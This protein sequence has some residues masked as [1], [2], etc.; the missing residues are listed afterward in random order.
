[1]LMCD[2]DQTNTVIINQ[3][4]I[5]KKFFLK[6]RE[7]GRKKRKWK[8]KKKKTKTKKKTKKPQS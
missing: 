3:L 5:K 6:E 1:M 8:K 4:K 2:R 7:S